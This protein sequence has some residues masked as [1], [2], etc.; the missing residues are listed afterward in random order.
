MKLYSTG[1]VNVI[2]KDKNGVIKYNMNP[3]SI[4]NIL[5]SNNLLK[6][7]LKNKELIIPFSTLN[8]SK[9]TLPYITKILII[10]SQFYL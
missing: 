4:V 8:E 10:L 7:N 6:I 2:I 5:V 9:L 3:F 1:D